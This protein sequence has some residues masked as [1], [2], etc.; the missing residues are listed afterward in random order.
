VTAA[1]YSLDIRLAAKHERRIEEKISRTSPE[2]AQ[3]IKRLVRRDDR[4]RSLAAGI[5]IAEIIGP[6]EILYGPHG[7]PFAPGCRHF[8]AA[9]SGNFAL[10]AAGNEPIGV[11][12][13]LWGSDDFLALASLSFCPEERAVLERDP[14]PQVFYDFWVLKESYVK[15]LGTGFSMDPR[16]FC[17]HK[18]R[19]SAKV[20]ETSHS[21]AASLRLL[22]LPGYSAAVCSA[23]EELPSAITPMDESICSIFAMPR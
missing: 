11:D 12:L 19:I 10:L 13:E 5:L 7:K 4:L 9:H 15:M 23:S 21:P 2:R 1:V 14:S 16:S 3:K 8:N 20:N 17:V 6:R 22:N 18:E